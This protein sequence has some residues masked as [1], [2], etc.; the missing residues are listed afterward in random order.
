MSF[1][2]YLSFLMLSLFVFIS[3]G[4]VAIFSMHNGIHYGR[5]KALIATLGNVTALFV[6]LLIAAISLGVVTAL[7]PKGFM[8]LQLLGAGYLFYLG[9]KMALNAKKLNGQ[10]ASDRDFISLAILYR[11]GF[12][13]TFTNP[14]AFAYVVAVIPQFLVVKD[15]LIPQL[16][17]MAPT[18]AVA[19]FIC[20]SCYVLFANQFREWFLSSRNLEWVNYIAGG[21]LMT[22]ALIMAL[23]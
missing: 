11:R 2:Q 1:P 4:P 15:D 12:F 8:L 21:I 23:A 5:N 18:I 3:P 9:L 13:M 19:Q 7:S 10:K 22:F 16:L 17:I 14:K 6:L 20:I